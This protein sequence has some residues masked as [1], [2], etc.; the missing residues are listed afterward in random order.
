MQGDS[1][2]AGDTLRRAVAAAEEAWRGAAAVEA[3][4]ERRRKSARAASA[5]DTKKKKNS[6]PAEPLPPPLAT[7]ARSLLALASCLDAEGG[8]TAEAL[9]VARRAAGLDE[10]AERM[11]VAPLVEKL[12]R[13]REGEGGKGTTVK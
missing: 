7:L 13:E 10:G 8:R 12:R 6:P 2:A 1:E 5:K 3:E 11:A 4:V 9:A